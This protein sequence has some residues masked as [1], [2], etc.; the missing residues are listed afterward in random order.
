MKKMK[1]DYLKHLGFHSQTSLCMPTE[2]ETNI[3]LES[4]FEFKTHKEEPMSNNNCT[5]FEPIWSDGKCTLC[6]GV[7]KTPSTNTQLPDEVFQRG[8]YVQPEGKDAIVLVTGWVNSTDRFIG[9][10]VE[11]PLDGEWP[12]RLGEH[13][14]TWHTKKFKKV[15]YANKLLQAQQEIESLTNQ[16]KKQNEVQVEN[17]KVMRAE[18]EKAY[19][20][21]KRWKEEAKE[22]LQPIWDFADKKLGVPLGESKVNAVM[23]Y[24]QQTD[25]VLAL[26]K[27]ADKTNSNLIENAV[28]LLEK[29]ISRH[30]AGLLPD[31]FIYNEIKTFLDGTK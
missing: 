3:I 24:I 23:K 6:G 9:T 14:D 30:E 20:E 26:Y 2:R 11:A 17:M 13:S 16:L 27:Q 10:V 4:E 5:C 8:D 7:N 18:S 21:L 29:F 12:L 1:R 19:D 15:E 31:M 25:K 28:T 22:L